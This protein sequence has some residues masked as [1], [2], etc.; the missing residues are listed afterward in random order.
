MISQ[1]KKCYMVAV[2][3]APRLLQRMSLTLGKGWSRYRQGH[4]CH[5][6][7]PHKWVK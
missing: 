4:E 7:I 2:L 5:D 3:D 1:Q 6:I